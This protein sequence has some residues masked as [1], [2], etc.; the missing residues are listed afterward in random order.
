[1]DKLLE[2]LEQIP[3]SGDTKLDSQIKYIETMNQIIRTPIGIAIASS[4]KE[5]KGI[6]KKH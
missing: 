6:K 3:S 2:L 1:M 5:L 4:L